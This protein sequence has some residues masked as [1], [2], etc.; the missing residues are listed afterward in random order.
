ML[1]N[2][3]VLFEKKSSTFGQYF[4]SNAEVRK[5]LSLELAPGIEFEFVKTGKKRKCQFSSK[6]MAPLKFFQ[7]NEPQSSSIII[8]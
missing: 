5:F 1:R 8:F 2:R 7:D 4:E 3:G 6:F